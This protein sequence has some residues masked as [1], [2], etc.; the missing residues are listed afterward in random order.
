M[1]LVD[2]PAKWILRLFEME[3]REGRGAHC[4]RFPDGIIPPQVPL[5]A[6]E[7]VFGVYRDKYYFTPTS[8]IMSTPNGWQRIAWREIANCSSTHGDGARVCT[9]QLT[10]GTKA[11]VP[12]GE[13]AV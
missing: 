9:L 4:K 11:T 2:D 10:S 1:A 5:A 7:N 13:F 3:E 8:F 6:S 12:I